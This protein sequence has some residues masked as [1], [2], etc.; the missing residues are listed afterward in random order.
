M[1]AKIVQYLFRISIGIYTLL[2]G[3]Y[4]LSR[5]VGGGDEGLFISDLQLIQ[6]EGWWAAIEKG[7][8]IPYML[9][10]YPLS[11]TLDFHIALRGINILLFIGLLFYFYK[12]LGIRKMNFYLLLLFFFSTVGY[13]MVGTNDTL[14]VVSLVVFISETYTLLTQKEKSS[15]MVWG[16][17]MVV[18]FLT[19]ELFLVYVPVVLL[20]VV[21]LWK[22]KKGKVKTL[23]MPFLI[24]IL[25]IVLNIPSL[26]TSNGISYD[27][28]LP[29]E[30]IEATWPQRQYLAQLRV[31]EGSLPN[32]NHPNWEQT[33]AYLKEH[34]AE[35]L[36]K[37]TLE[38]MLFNPVLTIKEFFKDFM[39]S[40]TYG[41]RQLGLILPY[42]LFLF[43]VDVVRFQKVSAR[44]YIP[45]AVATMMG[46]FSLIVIS[47]VELR[48]LAPVF[49]AAIFYF[50][51][52]SEQ[53]KIPDILVMSNYAFMALLS[54]YGMLRFEW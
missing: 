46:V 49:M 48:W 25:G 15:L 28:K 33:D 4:F 34:G 13:F 39:Y 36:P 11:W 22:H 12:R 18:A 31:N 52:L 6:T 29:P 45:W 26:S 44:T 2:S 50:Y 51:K 20:S 54:W 19:R 42:L 41:V 27:Q 5:P 17:A 16:I 32:Y 9:L 37:T 47:F 1:I 24:L 14:F 43:F 53:R 3:Y 35:S 8:S 7:I 21:L 40:L 10:A 23:M 30:G 38:G